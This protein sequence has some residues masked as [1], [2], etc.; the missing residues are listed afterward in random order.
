MTRVAALRSEEEA[1][2]FEFRSALIRMWWTSSA[3]RKSRRSAHLL[4]NPQSP[5]LKATDFIDSKNFYNDSDCSAK[6]D[7]KWHKTDQS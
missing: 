1:A 7:A 5:V 2:S 6:K 4:F 3:L